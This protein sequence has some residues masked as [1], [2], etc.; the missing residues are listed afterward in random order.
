MSRGK[1][2]FIKADIQDA[3]L[4]IPVNHLFSTRYDDIYTPLALF[5]EVYNFE[6]P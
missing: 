2:A 3:L 5:E 4:G 6:N 1:M